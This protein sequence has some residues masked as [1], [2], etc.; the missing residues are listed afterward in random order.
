M[1]NIIKAA[2]HNNMKD[3]KKENSKSSHYKEKKYC[4]YF[5][6]VEHLYETTVHKNYYG[7]HFIT[8]LS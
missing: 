3:V 4:F 8:Y 6:N 2:V 7:N 5:F 1:I